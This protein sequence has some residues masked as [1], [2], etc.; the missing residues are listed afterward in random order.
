M[1]RLVGVQGL[2]NRSYDLYQSAAQF[3]A[4]ASG[5]HLGAQAL[6]EAGMAD[7]LCERNDLDGALAHLKQ[8][9]ALMPWWGKADDFVLSYATLARIHLAQADRSGAAEAVEKAAQ[10]IQTRGVFSEARR[11]A[12]IAQVK[13]WLAQGD[14]QA[15]RPL[16]RIPGRAL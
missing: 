11:A 14:A 5:Q 8:G 7:P 2:L 10:L 1:A 12:E 3:V 9:L 6:V 4:E 13:L 16:G 15:S